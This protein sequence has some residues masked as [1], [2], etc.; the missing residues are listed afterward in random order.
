MGCNSWINYG[1]CTSVRADHKN[2]SYYVT[3][4]IVML[5]KVKHHPPPPVSLLAVHVTVENCLCYTVIELYNLPVMQDKLCQHATYIY[6]I[7][8]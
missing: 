7:Q 6:I 3:V 5:K 2:T 8:S 4:G 1:T